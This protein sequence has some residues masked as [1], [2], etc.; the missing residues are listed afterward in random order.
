MIPWYNQFYILLQRYL[1]EKFRRWDLILFNVTLSL[2]AAT[3][4]GMGAWH[5]LDHSN[6]D[7]AKRNPLIMFCVMHQGVVSALQG[8]YSFPM[9]RAQMLRERAAGTYQVSAYFLAKSIAEMTFQLII[10]VLF[11]VTVYPL[12]S[13]NPNINNFFVFLV[14][15]T[16]GSFAATSLSNMMSC[17]F[18]SIELS[19]IGLAL[20]MEISRL[21]SGFFVSPKTLRTLSTFDSWKF[22]DAIS[23]MKYLYVGLCVNE[24]QGQRFYCTASE[25]KNG[26]CP[27]TT[28]EKWMKMYGYDAYSTEYCCG[29]L[30]AYIIVCR[31]CAYLSL[32]FIKM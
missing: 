4:I 18:V 29:M 14:L 6:T 30:C 8:T 21:Y 11:S 22:A 17:L 2:V 27:F 5:H 25:E 24:Y 31:I 28:G 19:T 10:P 9:E 12:T 26:V 1:V 16:L 13:L 15:N 3:F 20:V 7:L 23:Y 32:R